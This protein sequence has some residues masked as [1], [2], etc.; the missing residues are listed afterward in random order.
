M[1]SA[2]ADERASPAGV[3]PFLRAHRAFGRLWAARAVSFLGDSVGLVALLLYVAEHEKSGL[4]VALLMIAGDFAPNLLSPF[5]GALADRAG[6]RWLMPSCEIAQAGIIVAIALALP[7]LPVLLPLVAARA[8]IATVFQAA[9]RSVVASLVPE[10]QLEKAN[11]VLGLGTNGLD[12]LGPLLAAGLLP[13]LTISGLLLFD[14]GTFA[15]SAA[16]L[17]TLPRAARAG[18]PDHDGRK[19]DHDE[20]EPFLGSTKAGITWIWRHRYLRVIAIGFC[21]VVGFNGVDD[22][23]LVYLAKDSL[24]APAWGMSLLYAGVGAGLLA[25]FALLT[26]FP[27]RIPV[28]ALL[29]AGY[30]VSSLGNLLT[31]TAWAIAAAFGMQCVRGLGLSAM[32]TAHNTLIQRIVPAPLLGRVFANVYGA[33]SLAAGLSYLFGGLLLDAT[34]P[35]VTLI[36]AGAGGIAVTPVVAWRLRAAGPPADGS[37]YR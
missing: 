28:V 23:A 32:D 7:G 15:V 4:A 9:S 24:H 2:P 11:A 21:A 12:V 14:A 29:L 8:T 25:G 3:V 31:G 36:A 35:R 16:F 26:R 13:W 33:V 6:A 34:N 30:L 18:P 19:S 10:D 27:H 22:V 17:V 37:C 1:T 5:A 20:R